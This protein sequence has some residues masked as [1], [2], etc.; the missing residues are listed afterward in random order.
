M[1]IQRPTALSNVVP[2]TNTAVNTRRESVMAFGMF[3]RAL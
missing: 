3:T 2:A 1:A